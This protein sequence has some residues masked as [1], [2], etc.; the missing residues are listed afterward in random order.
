MHQ[1]EGEEPL[2]LRVEIRNKGQEA[3]KDARVEIPLPP[4]VDFEQVTEVWWTDISM[5]GEVNYEPSLGPGGTL[6]W[7]IGEV[8]VSADPDELIGFMEYAIIAPDNC[9]GPAGFQCTTNF[10]LSG[11]VTGKNAATDVAFSGPVIQGFDSD[12]SC[13]LNPVSDPIYF[14]VLVDEDSCPDVGQPLAIQLCNVVEGTID[15][16]EIGSYFPNGTRFYDT[17]PVPDG[18][19]EYTAGNPFPKSEEARSFVA[20][21]GD[22]ASCFRPFTLVHQS[23]EATVSITSDYEGFAISCFGASDGAVSVQ[24]EGGSPPY[25][26]QWDDPASSNSPNLENLTPGIYTVTVTDS[27]NCSATASVTLEQPEPV[28][29]LMDTEGSNFDLGCDSANEALVVFEIQEELHLWVRSCT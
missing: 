4:T 16:S 8:P 3:I 6:V 17:F 27:Q 11:E 9:S 12:G 7:K 21:L 14:E 15:V 23:M 19:T 26:Y 20:V 2:T 13:N 18:A 24:V 28:E 10:D 22:E 5:P 1:V 25:A 29:I